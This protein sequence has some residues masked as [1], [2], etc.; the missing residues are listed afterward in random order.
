MDKIETIKTVLKGLEYTPERVAAAVA[1]LDGRDA[2]NGQPEIFL[3]PKDLCACLKISTTTLWRMRP[4]H[5]W[6]G[7]RK[8]YLLPEV[9]A[10]LKSSAGS[11]NDFSS[12]VTNVEKQ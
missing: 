8:R 11:E 9:L 4:P 6:V 7:R 12:R 1:A 3:T 10:A 2:P 5:H